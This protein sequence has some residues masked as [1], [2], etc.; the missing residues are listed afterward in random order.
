[1]KG[2]FGVY[3]QITGLMYVA[4][5]TNLLLLIANLP[6]V[7]L[8]VFTD[9]TQTWLLV[10]G[11]APFAAP[12]L[13]AAFAVFRE[14]AADGRVTVVRS[15]VLRLSALWR[16]SL[17]IGALA[18][19]GLLVIGADIAFM[20][21][22][23]MGAAAIPV[24]VMFMAVLLATAFHVLVAIDLEVDVKGVDLWKACLFLTVRHWPVTT[25]S[26]VALGLLSTFVVV[27]PAWGLGLA[28]SPV[29]YLAWTNGSYVLRP[30]VSAPQVRVAV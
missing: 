10:V 6:L 14:F 19:A 5:M 8:V 27:M 7:V 28:V 24:F 16:R 26:L 18:S 1:M 25:L 30:K 23:T 2:F 29:L 12:S 4:L 11:V 21:G 15:F 22:K 20:W 13:V 17:G 3:L 9:V